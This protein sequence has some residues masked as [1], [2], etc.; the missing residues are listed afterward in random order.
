AWDHRAADRDR[1]A[2]V[3]P[4]GPERGVLAAA[5]RV[6]V[7]G[8][9]HGADRPLRAAGELL[10]RASRAPAAADLDVADLERAAPAG[11]GDRAARHR[12]GEGL[13]APAARGVQ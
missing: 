1:G 12:L 8:V 9:P 3:G 6:R 4:A 11:S 2:L 5:Q 13:R 7:R 10:E